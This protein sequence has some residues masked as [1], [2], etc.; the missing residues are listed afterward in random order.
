MPE[1]PATPEPKTDG[2]QGSVIDPR[3][4][5]ASAR[6]LRRAM[7]HG[8]PVSAEVMAESVDVL[9]K[10]AKSRNPKV[11]VQAARTLVAA[12]RANIARMAIAARL[13]EQH[14]QTVNQVNVQVVAGEVDKG[15]QSPE[16]L[17]F[18]RQKEAEG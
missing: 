5:R 6:L 17:E 12:D 8:W 9:R 11:A 1:T 3:R 13:L 10:L 18:L 2:G 7:L 16:Y 14:G 15:L 4:P